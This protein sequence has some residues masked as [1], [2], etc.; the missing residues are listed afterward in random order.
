MSTSD[1]SPSVVLPPNEAAWA[2]SLPPEP[3]PGPLAEISRDEALERPAAATGPRAWV[4]PDLP[5]RLQLV[6]AQLQVPFG[7][8][9]GLAPGC[10]IAVPS[11]GAELQVALTADSVPLATGR[12]VA[13][14]DGY[15]VLVDRLGGD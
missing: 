2:I 15:G 9:G 11:A 6:I 4:P 7:E 12:L 8:L 3:G 10:V 13:L 5:V 14:G 1:L